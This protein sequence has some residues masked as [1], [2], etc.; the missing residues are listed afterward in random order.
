MLVGICE[1]FQDF[2]DNSYMET[3]PQEL[4]E[5][6]DIIECLSCADGCDTLLVMQKET[7]KKYVAKCYTESSG[8]FDKTTFPKIESVCSSALPYFVMAYQNEKTRCFLR[9]YIEGI[10]LDQYVKGHIM[11]EDVARDLAVKL[12]KEMKA[13]HDREAVI[14]HRDIKPQNIIIRDDGSVALIDF[15]IS[16]VYKQSSTSDTVFC[17]TEGFA[18]PEQYGFMQTDIRSDI[19]SF[20]VVLSWLLTGKEQ[21]IKFPISKLEKIAAKCCAFAPDKRYQNDDVL[22]HALYRTSHEHAFHKR[23]R[24]KRI[25]FGAG[26]LVVFSIVGV[27]FYQAAYRNRFVRF[28]EPLIEEAARLMLG[29]PKGA[30]TTDDLAQI[31]ELYI[32]SDTVC[33]S[34]NEFYEISGAWYNT[35]SRIR[36]PITD[37]SDLS[38]MLNLKIVFIE[39]EQISDLSAMKDL[40]GLQVL[41]LANNNIT[42]LS[43]LAGKENLRECSLLDNGLLQEIGAIRTWKGIRAL[44]LDNTGHYDGSAIGTFERYDSLAVKNDSDAWKYLQGKYIGELEIGASGQTDIGFIRDIPYIRRLYIRWSDIRDISALTG[45]EDITF[46]NMEECAIDDLSPLFTMPNLVT[47]EMSAIEQERMESLIDKYGEPSFEIVYY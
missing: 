45:R 27:L 7:G 41:N 8:I 26:V 10:S 29:M 2:Y 1:E 13:L 36:G 37:I 12:A 24:N 39:A 42:D 15:G 44:N 33:A 4:I 28:Q 6:Y 32:Q 21:P 14:I 40:D 11:T 34:M 31:E 22:L 46:L 17:G 20:G 43:P 35:D 3:L 23:K 19:Y 16:C 18:P 38:Y 47:V 9:E 5:A 30:L 25:A